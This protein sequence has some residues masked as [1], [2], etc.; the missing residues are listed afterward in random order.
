MRINVERKW[1]AILS[2]DWPGDVFGGF[3]AVVDR[4]DDT[5]IWE[6]RLFGEM[7]LE[8]AERD[9]GD[10]LNIQKTYF[11]LEAVDRDTVRVFL[12]P[13]GVVAEDRNAGRLYR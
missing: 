9:D 5:S 12:I 3:V 4:D 13:E 6:R 1:K 8:S 7:I 10:L 2:E 11:F